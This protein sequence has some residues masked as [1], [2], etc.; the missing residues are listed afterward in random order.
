PPTSTS[1]PY[2]TLFRS[3]LARRR[4][5]SIGHHQSRLTDGRIKAALAEGR[6]QHLPLGRVKLGRDG[7]GSG[8]QQRRPAFDGLI[9]P[10]G[11]VAAD[12][13]STRLNSSHVSI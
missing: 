2:T 9:E 12:R 5:Q 7:A 3:R 6:R 10:A 13:K 11:A 8:G 4:R 1:F